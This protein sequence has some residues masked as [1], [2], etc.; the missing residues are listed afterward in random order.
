MHPE[1]KGDSIKHGDLIDKGS[2][3]DLVLG[4]GKNIRILTPELIGK[5]YNDARERI[6]LSNLNT[7]R[8]SFD[9]SV[10][11][12]SDSLNAQVYQQS[13]AYEENSKIAPGSKINLWLTIDSLKIKD[14]RAYLKSQ[15]KQ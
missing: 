6:L 12:L 8:I 15:F 13:H 7:G 14:A 5:Y 11:N 10:F 3:I 1:F 2:R 4:K 9:N